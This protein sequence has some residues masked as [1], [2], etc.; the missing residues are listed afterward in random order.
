[1]SQVNG[2]CVSTIRRREPKSFPKKRVPN[3]AA[4][5]PGTI[6]VQGRR[7]GHCRLLALPSRVLSLSQTVWATLHAVERAV[8]CRQQP[9]DGRA[10]FEKYGGADAHG[11]GRILSVIGDALAD[12]RGNLLGLQRACLWKHHSELVAPISRR[13]VDLP[14][15][16]SQNLG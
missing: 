15:M 9:L 14:A 10:V 5:S 3:A 6:F 7:R 11:D 16:G 12:S 2:S 13:R 1:M 4:P 8:C